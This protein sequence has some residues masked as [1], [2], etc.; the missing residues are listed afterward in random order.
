MFVEEHVAKQLIASG[1]LP[2][3]PGLIATTPDAAYG[4]A[5]ELLTAHPG[6]VMVKAQMPAGNHGRPGGSV[7]CASPTDAREV[8]DQ[9][10][11]SDPGG[12]VVDR[13]L[14]E[15]CF[16]IAREIWVAITVDAAA[17]TPLLLLS[18]ERSITFEGGIEQ[19]HATNADSVQMVSINIGTGLGAGEAMDIAVGT[20]LAPGMHVALAGLLLTLYGLFRQYDAELLEINPLAI[21]T[22]HELV[23]LGCKL[24]VDDNAL[25]RQD[26]V[27]DAVANAEA[28]P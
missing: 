28:T 2:V 16:S 18:T 17:G 10:L 9:L 3:P 12:I 26:A 19:V 5:S 7:R 15:T 1:G 14:V 23:A 21:T 8:A 6:A 13:V 11:G 27:R 20:D 24:V 4:A 25:F 22:S